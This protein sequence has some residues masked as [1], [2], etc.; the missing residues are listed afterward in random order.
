MGHFF[1][2]LIHNED[3][4]F[5]GGGH[6]RIYWSAYV[7]PYDPDLDGWARGSYPP[8]SGSYSRKVIENFAREIA[9]SEVVVFSRLTQEESLRKEILEAES[10]ASV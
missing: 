10:D 7:P 6:A 8:Q 5:G 1:T 2:A 3:I 9:R 4:Y